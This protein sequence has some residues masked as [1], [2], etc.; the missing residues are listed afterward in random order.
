MV[1]ISRSRSSFAVP[2]IRSSKTGPV[3]FLL[4][5]TQIFRL[6]APLRLLL[7]IPTAYSP[8]FEDA[9]VWLKAHLSDS[10]T[11]RISLVI[12]MCCHVNI[13]VHIYGGIRM[14]RREGVVRLRRGSKRCLI[15]SFMWRKKRNGRRRDILLSGPLVDGFRLHDRTWHLEYC[16]VDKARVVEMA[17][18][19]CIA[20]AMIGRLLVATSTSTFLA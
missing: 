16:K 19:I 1:A 7:V 4:R 5:S 8:M 20:L 14:K 13:D 15:R 9:M 18:T 17:P 6:S 10:F 12:L 11:V 2:W 3:S